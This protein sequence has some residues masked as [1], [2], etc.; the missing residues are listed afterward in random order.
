MTVRK[1]AW[2]LEGPGTVLIGE[3]FHCVEIEADFR[4]I[5]VDVDV[6][7]R[8]SFFVRRT[9][10]GN[11]DMRMPMVLV[12]ARQ[13]CTTAVWFYKFHLHDH[14]DHRKRPS[15]TLHWNTNMT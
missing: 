7:V 9:S 15:T 1:P 2:F 4:D 5:H 3:E 14:L 13:Q 10:A 8:P 11:V 12:M 6:D